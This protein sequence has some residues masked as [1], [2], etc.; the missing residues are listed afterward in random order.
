MVSLIFVPKTVD[1][2]LSKRL[3]ESDRKISD[4][5]GDR[6]KV[7]ECLGTK[8]KELLHKSNPWQNIKCGR[9]KCL[10]CNCPIDKKFNCSVRSV[11][12]KT[13]CLKC[14]EER[15]MKQGGLEENDS[16]NDATDVMKF[17]YGESSKTA[18][19]RGI[20]HERDYVNKQDDSHMYKH[21]TEA[22]GDSDMNDVK[23]GMTVLRSHPSAFHRLRGS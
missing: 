10:V 8:L 21:F 15:K 6:C 19:E 1:G 7:V 11:T 3:R 16:K 22:H 20:L 12:Y 18:F 9:E 2:E 23:F 14:E 5:T 4:I 17:Y 13:F